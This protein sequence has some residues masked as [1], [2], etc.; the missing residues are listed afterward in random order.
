MTLIYYIP[1]NIKFRYDKTPGKKLSFWW[2]P[3][4][5]T[6]LPI[7]LYNQAMMLA[8][9]VYCIRIPNG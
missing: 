9:I 2:H 5:I 7:T 8:N 3:L 4:V 6:K 1:Y